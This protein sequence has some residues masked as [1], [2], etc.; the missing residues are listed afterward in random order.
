MAVQ[1]EIVRQTQILADLGPDPRQMQQGKG[2][3]QPPQ[4]R[5]TQY[6]SPQGPPPFQNNRPSQTGPVPM[7]VNAARMGGSLTDDEKQRLMQ[8]NKCFYCKEIG[9]RTRQCPKK[10][11]R[12]PATACITEVKDD[13]T[14]SVSSHST[15]TSNTSLT[16]EGLATQLCTMASN[17]QSALFDQMITEDLDF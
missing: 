2:H 3:F 12:R 13:D 11:P 5:P 4:R 9:H 6:P 10:P 8:E 14:S 1:A 17:E 16:S 15:T 7:D